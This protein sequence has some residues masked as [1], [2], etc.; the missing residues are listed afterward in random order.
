MTRPAIL[1][2]GARFALVAGALS[3]ATWGA[4]DAL[5]RPTLGVDDAHLAQRSDLFLPVVRERE[6]L[7]AAW[8][9]RWVGQN[10]AVGGVLSE[11][12]FRDLYQL[13]ILDRDGRHV[14]VYVRR[15]VLP[16]LARR[17]V[18]LEV[19]GSPDA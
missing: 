10:A 17:G 12:R 4:Y 5:G 7:L 3:L 13:A 16:R 8:R 11:S 15:D 1:V 6:K 2:R 9:R 18:G 14:I 19:V